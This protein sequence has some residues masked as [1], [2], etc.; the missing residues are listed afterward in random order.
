MP[1]IEYLAAELL[2]HIFESCERV[3][4][5][6]AL[7]ATCHRLHDISTSSQQ[8]LFLK[9]AAE[10]QFGPLK[11][12]L[13]V[14]TQNSSQAVHIVR[15]EDT[16]AWSMMLFKQLFKLGTTANKWADLYPFKKWKD[17]FA[18]RRLL[19]SDE[20][21]RVRRAVYRLWLYNSAFHTPKYPRESRSRPEVKQA[22]A[23][24]LHNYSNED[25]AELADVRAIMRDVVS[26]N[27]CPSNGA[28]TRKFRQRHGDDA[29]QQLIFNTANIS[30]H[31]NFPPPA[32]QPPLFCQA[33]NPYF[34]APPND[35]YHHSP[36]Y[37]SQTTRTK[38][39]HLGRHGGI[40]AGAEGWGDNLAHYYAVQD[41]LKLDPETLL[42][43]KEKKLG[44]AELVEWTR[45][46]GDWFQN[47][48]E[49]WSETA[50]YV[51]FERGES[52]LEVFAT[53]G[54]VAREDYLDDED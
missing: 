4:D 52:T 41:M 30:I 9:K 46:F 37:L 13:Q 15:S 22:R 25:L 24:L 54:I 43:L 39:Y 35:L 17:N 32:P 20:R 14:A 11:D 10:R 50:E 40:E 26:Q 49:T 23:Q 48:G 34:A 3:Q 29:V 19:T 53:G 27:I 38:A 44:R 8:M 5:V 42:W 12:M 45:S 16:I 47:S 18:D 36:V 28:I 31:L 1:H 7:G 6:L 33:A 2:V 21:M 51:L